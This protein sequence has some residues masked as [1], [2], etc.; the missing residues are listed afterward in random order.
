MGITFTTSYLSAH[1]PTAYKYL[2]VYFPFSPNHVIST[3]TRQALQEPAV[4]AEVPLT[5]H[6]DL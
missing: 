5:P 4:T 2:D 3:V 1:F 6:R